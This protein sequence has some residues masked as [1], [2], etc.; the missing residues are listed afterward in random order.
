[1]RRPFYA[2]IGLVALTAV[3]IQ[4]IASGPAA[5]DEKPAVEAHALAREILKQLIEINTTH[6]YG[7]TA[8]A[9]AVANRLKKAGFAADDVEVVAPKE[10]PQDGNLIVHFRGKRR[11]AAPILYL[12][13]LDTVEAR[14]E[15]WTVDPFRLTE[16]GGWLY[17]RGTA[18]MKGKDA[19]V[20]TSLI[21]LKREKIEPARDLIAVFTANE[22]AGGGPD[23]AAW[24]L[25]TRRDLHD[26]SLVINP[27][28]GEAGTKAGRRMFLAIETSEKIFL[29]FRIS[30]TDKGGHSA[31][32]TPQNP[33][34]RV[35][36]ALQRLAAFRFPVHLTETTR[37]YFSARA[38]LESGQRQ[39]DMRLLGAAATSEEVVDRLSEDVWLNALLRTTCTATMVDGGHAENALPQSA[40]ATLQCRVIPGES[41]ESVEAALVSVISDPNIRIETITPATPSPESPLARGLISLTRSVAWAEWP[42]L[43]VLPEMAVG[44]TDS[45]YFRAAGIPSYGIDGLFIDL[46]DVRAHG[47]D[48]RIGVTAFSQ[49]VDFMYLLMKRTLTS[50]PLTLLPRKDR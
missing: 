5:A 3:S 32:P 24:L 17:G 42:N 28:G 19:A 47:R 20:L 18:D 2:A 43:T 44:A 29:T 37:L 36:A 23:G 31:L 13:H 46:D 8:A 16:S 15:D 34:Y 49:E 6:A 4:P 27:D 1:M 41:P 38:A 21:L 33:I 11:D 39:S 9:Y 26:A 48:E 22:E 30:A 10:R 14:R 45:K 35:A 25:D 50:D 12:C 7:T 40:R